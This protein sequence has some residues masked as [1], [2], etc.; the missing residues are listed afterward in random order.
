MRSLEASL[1][2]ILRSYPGGY[3]G[4]ARMLGWSSSRVWRCA[5]G[6]SSYSAKDRDALWGALETANKIGI[7]RTALPSKRTWRKAWRQT[8]G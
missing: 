7:L 6:R 5:H 3:S 1:P 4:L 8:H 2:D